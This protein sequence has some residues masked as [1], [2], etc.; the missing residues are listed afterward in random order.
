MIQDARS[1]KQRVDFLKTTTSKL[2]E[3]GEENQRLRRECDEIQTPFV[4]AIL[5]MSAQDQVIFAERMVEIYTQDF[6]KLKASLGIQAPSSTD[7]VSSTES[8]S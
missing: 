3:L 7:P 6:E 2:A 1:L 5:A 4:E 8:S